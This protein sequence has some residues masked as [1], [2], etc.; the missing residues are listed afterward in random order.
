MARPKMEPPFWKRK[1]LEEMNEAEWESL[2]DGCGRC[3]LVK[4]EED[5]T[6]GKIHFTDLA[7]TLLD[8]PILPLPRLSPTGRP[9]CTIA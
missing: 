9:T 6:S 5:E 1:S 7:C 8:A 3:C 2:C 4:L